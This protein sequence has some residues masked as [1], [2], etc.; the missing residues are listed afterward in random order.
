MNE[1]FFLERVVEFFL[2]GC[3][4]MRQKSEQGERK[5]ETAHTFKIASDIVNLVV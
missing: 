3:E 4:R 1:V 2:K 5:G